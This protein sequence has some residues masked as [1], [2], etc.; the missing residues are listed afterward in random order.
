MISNKR[1]VMNKYRNLEIW[2]LGIA[3]AK[4]VY[5]VTQHLPDSER[6]RLSSQMRRSAC[7]FSSNVAEG[8]GRNSSREF[9][10]FLGIA[11]GS[12]C[13]L[14]TQLELAKSV[15]MI[16]DDAYSKLTSDIIILQKMTYT[17]MKRIQQDS[18]PTTKPKSAIV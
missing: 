4:E 14:D 3:L 9:H 13:E 11:C 18:N 12:L 15:Q 6:Y 10:H 7:S 2:K 1:S 17:L 8:S 5:T 16:S